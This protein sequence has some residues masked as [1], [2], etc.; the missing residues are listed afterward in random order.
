MV[1]CTM[2]RHSAFALTILGVVVSG[3]DINIFF[4]LDSVVTAVVVV[5]ANSNMMSF[6]ETVAVEAT[7]LN[8]DGTVIGGKAF[9]WISSDPSIAAVFQLVPVQAK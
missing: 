4:P 8:S 9:T 1:R 7:A 6:G 2:A 5:P 3:C